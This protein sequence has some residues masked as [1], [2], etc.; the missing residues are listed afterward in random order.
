M[1][2]PCSR[3]GHDPRSDFPIGSICRYWI[4][5]VRV[6]GHT[7]RRVR[8][9]SLKDSFRSIVD[10]CSLM[11]LPDDFEWR[12]ETYDDTKYIYSNWRYLNFTE[13]T[14]LR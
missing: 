11:L 1:S 10:P 12:E 5:I 8:I 2:N 14:G 6:E 7:L 4:R 13:S 9:S 3:C